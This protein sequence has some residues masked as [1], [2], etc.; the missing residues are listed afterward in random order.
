MSY[1]EQYF[2]YLKSGIKQNRLFAA[3]FH[4]PFPN[5]HRNRFWLRI[6]INVFQESKNNKIKLCP[7]LAVL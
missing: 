5:A 7:S 1:K 6:N 4:L 2:N 3:Y